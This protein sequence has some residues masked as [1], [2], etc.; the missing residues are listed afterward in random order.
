MKN[1]RKDSWY[2]D[3]ESNWAPP[4]YKSEALSPEPTCSVRIYLYPFS[5]DMR[6]ACIQGVTT[7]S[8]WDIKQWKFYLFE[9]D[10]VW[11]RDQYASAKVLAQYLMCSVSFLQFVHQ[12]LIL[13]LLSVTIHWSKKDNTVNWKVTLSIFA[14]IIRKRSCTHTYPLLM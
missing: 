1:L 3:Q 5:E 4:E 12:M 7:S 14:W 13:S 8:M 2:L 9:T 10:S 11:H 6:N